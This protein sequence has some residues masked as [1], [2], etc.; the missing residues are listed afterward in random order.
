MFPPI[1]ATLAAAPAVTAIVGASPGRI[2]RHGSAPQNVDR[3]YVTWAIVSAVPENNLSDT[4]PNDRVSVQVD[5][6]SPDDAQAEALALAVRDAL[7]PLAH[8]TGVVANTQD[9]ETRLYRVGMQFDW[10]LMRP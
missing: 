8:M 7:E 4:P 10:I 2:Y 1:Y 5:A 3:P 9:A 6:W